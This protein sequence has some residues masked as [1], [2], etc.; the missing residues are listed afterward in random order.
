[1]PEFTLYNTLNMNI[2]KRDL[3]IIQKTKLTETI[4]QLDQNG[5]DLIYAIIKYHDIT[6]DKTS[7][8]IYN[9]KKE[10]T[11]VD[12]IYDIEW[13]MTDIPIPLRQILYKFVCLEEQRMN[14]AI[15]RHDTQIKMKNNIVNNN[16]K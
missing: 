10:N 15:E 5:T 2:P 1:M 13:N 16:N 4:P 11:S 14:D 7:N 9:H 6:I 8:N 3:T 12:G